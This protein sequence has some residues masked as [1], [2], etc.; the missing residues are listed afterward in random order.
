MSTNEAVPNAA[1]I[2]IDMRNL[3]R[4][5]KMRSSD[6]SKIGS[7]YASLVSQIS[8]Q[9]VYE[10]GHLIE[11]L[12]GVRDKVNSDGDRLHHE[13]VQHSAFSRSIIELTEII[14]DAVTSVSNAATAI[15]VPKDPA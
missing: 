15:P 13:I 2:E 5:K 6:E 11:G 3:L 7:D 14:S 1:A 10:I 9:S 8:A 4:A 12:Q